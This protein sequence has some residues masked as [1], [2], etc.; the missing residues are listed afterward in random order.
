M[1]EGNGARLCL[2]LV[3]G[4][5][6]TAV[7]IAASPLTTGRLQGDPPLNSFMR[8][9]NFCGHI[10]VDGGTGWVLGAPGMGYCDG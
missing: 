10:L 5:E 3:E 9:V 8:H 4:E 2:V 6:V 7:S 1:F